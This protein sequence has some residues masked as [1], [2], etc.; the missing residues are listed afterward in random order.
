MKSGV[1]LL[2]FGEPENPVEAEVVPFLERIF[3]VNAGLEG[4]MPPEAARARSR[5][6]ALER[7]PGL[8]AEYLEIGGSP[9]NRQAAEQAELLEAE[10][11]RRGHDV[12][13][14]VGMQFTDPLIRTAAERARDAGVE[15]L[16]ALPV[17]PLCGPS[18]TVAALEALD[19]AIREMGWDVEVHEISGW[20]NHPDYVALRADGILLVAR[21]HGLDLNDGATRLVFSAHGTPVKYLREGS[22][23]DR[24]VEECCRAVAEAAGVRDY[25][26]GYQN[27]GNRPIE[28]TQPAIEDVIREVDAENVV[29]VPI[30]FM[31]EQSETLAELD[32]ELREEAEAAGLGF[33]RVPIAHADPRFIGMLGDLVEPFLLGGEAPASS[34]FAECR[35]REGRG[36]R[37][38]RSVPQA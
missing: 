9:L 28:W 24:Y 3:Y 27:H 1:I 35:C 33:Y 23:Y 31:H 17:Y 5:Q 10:L 30:S 13:A 34:G 25:V 19:A 8:I 29:V 20:H 12:V 11:R 32:G 4:R 6:L 16:V 37:C 2:N 7:A 14:L 26:I 36:T 22:R 15:R 18:T 38:L 21:E